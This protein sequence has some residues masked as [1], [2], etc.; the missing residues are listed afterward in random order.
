MGDR[1]GLTIT[2]CYLGLAGV[3]RPGDK[4]LMGQVIRGFDLNITDFVLD[5]DASV[6]WAGATAAEPGIIVISGT[7]SIIFGV[8]H[9]G[10]RARAGGWGPILGDEGGGYDLGRLA[11]VAALKDHDGRGL[12]TRLK[13]LLVDTLKLTDITE[14]VN[15]VYVRKMERHEIASL[16][17]LVLRAAAEGDQVAQ[18]LV[19]HAAAE[20]AAGVQAVAKALGL[21]GR[22]FTIALAGGVFGAN[23]PLQSAI[24]E[25]VLS[26][27]TQAHFVSPVFSPVTG[28]LILAL[29][30]GGQ[31]VTCEI[32]GNLREGERRTCL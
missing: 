32:A 5:N 22:R 2:C 27:A 15:R 9:E 29:R 17:P 3:D 16:A 30:H 26:F 7:G 12:S 4:E 24:T 31:S 6:A 28:G 25:R 11:M 14:L 18:G 13:E 19:D 1:P 21:S 20:L 10:N 23:N 8:N